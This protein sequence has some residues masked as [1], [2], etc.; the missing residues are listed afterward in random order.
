MPA[1]GPHTSSAA[2]LP[3]PL[4]RPG[5]S[6]RVSRLLSSGAGVNRKLSSIGITPGVLLT[7][8]NSQTGPLLIRVG[9][10]RVGI[11]RG[12]AHRVLVEPCD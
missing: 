1:E 5:Q 9:D 11:S 6:A 8:L 12:L 7:V 2:E 3:L 10:T 4:L